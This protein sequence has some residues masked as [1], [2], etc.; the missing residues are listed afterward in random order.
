MEESGNRE[1]KKAEDQGQRPPSKQGLG[2]ALGPA[3][4]TEKEKPMR[5]G[6]NPRQ[7]AVLEVNELYCYLYG[8]F[9]SNRNKS[10]QSNFDWRFLNLL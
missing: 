3:K 10:Y 5:R 6:E 8:E 4:E 9:L 7:C 1:E 2:E